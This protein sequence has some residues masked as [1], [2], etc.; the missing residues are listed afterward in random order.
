[1][2]P[3]RIATW[4]VRLFV[5]S[6]HI[7]FVM[8]HYVRELSLS[9]YPQI[10]ALNTSEFVHQV[11]Y[12]SLNYQFLNLEDVR[13]AIKGEK[14]FENGVVLTFDDGYSDHYE[15]VFPLLRKLGIQGW[16]F[17]PVEAVVSN[18]ILDVNKIHFILA[19]LPESADLVQILFRAV[20]EL[21]KDHSVESDLRRF[22]QNFD[23][24]DDYDRKE[25][26]FFKHVLQNYLEDSL[27]A[28]ILNHLFSLFVEENASSFSSE[29]YMNLDQIREMKKAGMVIGG[30]G[31][32]H[33]WLGKISEREQSEEIKVTRDFLESV[34]GDGNFV[35][36]YPYGSYDKFTLSECAKR[37]FD[38][39]LTTKSGVFDPNSEDPLRVKRMDTNCFPKS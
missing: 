12:L 30:H 17:P 13:N 7:T 23:V 1:M 18:E 10:K 22:W 25:V 28:E 2:S 4:T 15:N 36:C 24:V 31:S 37:G 9:K 3:S 11:D 20:S 19:S 6:N 27:R 8:Y 21:E 14:T 34:N 35:M 26:T 5:M 39:G 16:F 38:I 33:R 32:Q 29:L